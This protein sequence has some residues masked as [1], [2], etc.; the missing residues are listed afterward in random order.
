M[1]TNDFLLCKF[2]SD[3]ARNYIA[4]I[5]AV[6]GNS[7]T[8]K[9]VHSGSIYEFET[10]NWTVAKPGQTFPVGT[11]LTEHTI[12]TRSDEQILPMPGNES[13]LVCVTFQDNNRYLGHLTQT[14]IG[15]E[16]H[17][18]FLHSGS[19]YVFGDDNTI[20]TSGGAYPAGQRIKGIEIYVPA[21]PATVDFSETE[22]EHISATPGALHTDWRSYFDIFD[23]EMMQ[24]AIASGK[25]ILQKMVDSTVAKAKIISHAFANPISGEELAKDSLKAGWD[26]ITGNE[27]GFIKKASTGLFKSIIGSFIEI[28]RANQAREVSQVRKGLYTAYADGC[29]YALYGDPSFSKPADSME[30]QFYD[31]GFQTVSNLAP[32]KELTGDATLSEYTR[33]DLLAGC[34]ES[35]RLRPG[36]LDQKYDLQAYKR[37]LSNSHTPYQGMMAK[38]STYNTLTDD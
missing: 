38:L 8:C 36:V 33:G 17:V 21:D 5:T 22:G 35:F 29:F 28:L 20:L 34:V 3:P 32:R 4:N 7:F 18:T 2:K 1:K 15:I 24:A 13:K 16:R 14:G 37:T 23:M 31:L 26:L 30:Q 25:D 9:F 10:T 27:A 6:N 19:R 11:P 12:Y